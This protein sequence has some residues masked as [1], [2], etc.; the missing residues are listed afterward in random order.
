ML[1]RVQEAMLHKYSPSVPGRSVSPTHIHM[2]CPNS[3]QVKWPESVPPQRFNCEGHGC[4]KDPVGTG[5]SRRTLKATARGGTI[6][7]FFGQGWLV[8][9]RCCKMDS[10]PDSGR[11]RHESSL[12]ILEKTQILAGVGAGRMHVAC[13]GAPSPRAVVLPTYEWGIA[14]TSV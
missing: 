13:A 5:S 8:G 7:L 2:S 4:G 9:D 14:R 11:N 12:N 10:Q 3:A 6:R 1:S